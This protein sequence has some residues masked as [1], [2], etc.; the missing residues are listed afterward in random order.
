MIYNSDSIVF[1]DDNRKGSMVIVGRYITNHS[2]LT[3]KLE[4]ID[5]TLVCYSAD[6]LP[7]I[8][9][10]ELKRLGIDLSMLDT[11]KHNKALH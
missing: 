10:A 7:T 11:I 2:A 3:G 9:I 8:I 5:N 4:I 6:I 1:N